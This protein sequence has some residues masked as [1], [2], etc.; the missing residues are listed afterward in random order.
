MSFS[1]LTWWHHCQVATTFWCPSFLPTVPTPPC[2]HPHCRSTGTLVKVNIQDF[3]HV[4][5]GS[6]IGKMEDN[7]K[8]VDPLSYTTNG[9]LVDLVSFSACWCEKK[10]SRLE[11]GWPHENGCTK[12]KLIRLFNNGIEKWKAGAVI[13]WGLNHRKG[14]KK[15]GRKPCTSTVCLPKYFV[16]L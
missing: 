8:S 3:L 5:Q 15:N 7:L 1:E 12:G 16:S 2:Q 10:V 4:F 11:S 14:R 6:G 9:P 13:S